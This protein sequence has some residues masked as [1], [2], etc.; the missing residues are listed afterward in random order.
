MSVRYTRK[1]FY[2]NRTSFFTLIVL[3]LLCVMISGRATAN[4]IMSPQDIYQ[5]LEAL[6]SNPEYL[7]QQQSTIGNQKAEEALATTEDTINKALQDIQNGFDWAHSQLDAVDLNFGAH[8]QNPQ[9]ATST[10]K[11]NTAQ[12]PADISGLVDDIRTEIRASAQ[13]TTSEISHNGTTNID[14]SSPSD[15]QTDIQLSNQVTTSFV[16]T[17]NIADVDVSPDENT[18]SAPVFQSL[19]SLHERTNRQ[20]QGVQFIRVPD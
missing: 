13:Q 16:D 4:T 8:Q 2:K 20:S 19:R 5:L 10:S 15:A 1:P 14:I 17:Q 12:V 6:Q 11:R 7:A 3:T 9:Q 18:E